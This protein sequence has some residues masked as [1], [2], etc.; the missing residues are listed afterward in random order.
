[1]IATALVVWILVI[2][3][4]LAA[5]GRRGANLVVTR[6]DGTRVS[7]ELIAVKPA[8]LLLLAGSASASV[9]LTDIKSVRILRPSKAGLFAGLAGAAGFIGGALAGL[10]AW[11]DEED[12]LA[13][14]AIAGLYLGAI[15]AV[16]GLFVGGIQGVDSTFSVAGQPEWILATHWRKL[17]V[18]S[19]EGRLPEAPA[20][21]EAGPERSGPRPRFRLSIGASLEAVGRISREDQGSF[22]FPGETPPE[23][24]PYPASFSQRNDLYR[25][26][27]FRPTSVGLGYEMTPRLVIEAEYFF[28]GS[29]TSF[30]WGDLE[31]TSSLDGQPYRGGGHGLIEARFSGFLVG[32]ALRPLAPSALDRHIIEIGAAA[33]PAQARGTIGLFPAEVIG[34]PLPVQKTTLAGRIRATYDFY[35]V[36]AVSFGAVVDWRYAQK[37]LS[38]ITSTGNANFV[39]DVEDSTV[40]F[41]RLTEVTFPPLVVK[42]TGF[43]WG[44]RVGVRL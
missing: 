16:S 33:G 20:A 41:L 42:A 22:R 10:K 36:P 39:E 14:G 9:E 24:G 1:M 2:P 28:L 6:L 15:G 37:N 21:L 13:Y 3:R 44:L 11:H 30:V 38:G 43:Y 31:F 26:R 12:Q 29:R 7:G 40:A 25:D 18:L 4:G 27:P 8:S 5:G 32:L 17:A 35:P 34:Q 23:A 19:R